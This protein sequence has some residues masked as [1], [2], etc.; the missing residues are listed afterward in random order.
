MIA[1]AAH[2]AQ[3]PASRAYR[4]AATAAFPLALAAVRL[5]PLRYLFLLI[6]AARWVGR[7]PLAA[8]DGEQLVAAARHAGRWWPGRIACLET[9]ITAVLAAAAC[10]R[11]LTWCIGVRFAPPPDSH[12]AWCAVPG[13]DGALL[14]VG[15]HTAAGWHYHPA[16]TI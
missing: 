9:S 15:E 13:P 6:R 12:H 14:P 16:H 4:L 8:G 7:R 5:L 2:T 3:V 1:D 11:A 10:G